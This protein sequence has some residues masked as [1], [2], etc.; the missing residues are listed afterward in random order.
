MPEVNWRAQ[1]P[2]NGAGRQAANTTHQLHSDRQFSGLAFAGAVGCAV[3]LCDVW[4]IRRFATPNLRL[5]HVL[6]MN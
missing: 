2:V 5:C 4:N 1:T 3:G 6:H